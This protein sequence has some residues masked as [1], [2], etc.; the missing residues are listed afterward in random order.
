MNKYIEKIALDSTP[1]VNIGKAPAMLQPAKPGE[2]LVRSAKT[3]FAKALV[4]KAFSPMSRGQPTENAHGGVAVARDH[5]NASLFSKIN[6]DHLK[7][8]R[9]TATIGAIGAGTGLLGAKILNRMP[10][11]SKSNLK[12]MALMGGLGL[13]GDYAAVKINKA[14]GKNKS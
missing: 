9:D 4:K 7:E 10:N 8:F 1:K 6:S 2:K 3:L 12:T 11:V 5:A 13:A 14:F